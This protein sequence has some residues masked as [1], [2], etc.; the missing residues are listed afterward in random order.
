MIHPWRLGVKTSGRQFFQC[1]FIKSISVTKVPGTG[2]HRRDTVVSMGMRLNP[3]IRSNAKEDCVKTGFR[4]ISLENHGFNL[5]HKRSADA[6]AC[7]SR[8]REFIG[9]DS[10]LRRFTAFIDSCHGSSPASATFQLNGTASVNCSRADPSPL[11]RGW[12]VVNVFAGLF[13]SIRLP[14]DDDCARLRSLVYSF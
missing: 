7:V 9:T 2:Y 8:P 3:R 1:G 10:D 11:G 12:M 13:E 6:G 5:P 4:G 14:R